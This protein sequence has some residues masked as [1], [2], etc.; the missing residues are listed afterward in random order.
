MKT[1]HQFTSVQI[2]ANAWIDRNWHTEAK[3]AGADNNY[4]AFQAF[5]AGAAFAGAPDLVAALAR[6]LN[7]ATAGLESGG[8][9]HL[10]LNIAKSEAR[11]ALARAKE[12][13]S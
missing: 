1:D 7:V 10:A 6:I 3:L 12:V 8:N 2:A 9:V 5:L 11:A 13:Q 4:V